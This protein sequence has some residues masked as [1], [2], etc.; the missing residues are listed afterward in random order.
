MQSLCTK[1]VRKTSL[2]VDTA[3]VKVVGSRFEVVKTTRICC[4]TENEILSLAKNNSSL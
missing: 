2:N 3:Q 4:W 1:K